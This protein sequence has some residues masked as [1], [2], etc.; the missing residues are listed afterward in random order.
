MDFSELLMR[1]VLGIVGFAFIGLGIF[2]GVIGTRG[3]S[4]GKVARHP[5][6]LL[7]SAVLSTGAGI[8]LFATSI[9]HEAPASLL[10]SIGH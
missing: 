4:G 10:R 2:Q 1:A 3:V 7:L 8:L 6:G 9:I 5:I